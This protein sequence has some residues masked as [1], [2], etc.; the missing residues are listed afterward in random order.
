MMVVCKCCSFRSFR[1][2]GQPCPMCGAP[3]TEIV[4]EVEE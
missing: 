2:D 3:F 4:Q 1:D